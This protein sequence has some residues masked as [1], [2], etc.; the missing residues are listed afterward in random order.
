[1]RTLAAVTD[2]FVPGE[3]YNIGG[4]VSHDMKEVSDLI[5][6]HLGKD[7]ASVT[8]AASEP[9]TTRDKRIDTRKAARALGHA[10]RVTLARTIAWMQRVYVDGLGTDPVTFLGT[11]A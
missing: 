3:V 11:D 1:M 4:A 6:A 9:F 2:T 8:Y 7:D 10:P 5:L